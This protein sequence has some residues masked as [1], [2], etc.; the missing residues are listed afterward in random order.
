VFLITDRQ[1]V[2][3]KGLLGDVSAGRVLT[4]SHNARVL[5]VPV[6]GDATENVAVETI[7][8]PSPP[9]LQDVPVSARIT[10]RN[11]GPVPRANVN[12]VVHVGDAVLGRGSVDLPA[13]G[14]AGLVVPVRFN[15]LGPQVLSASVEE[16]AGLPD[17]NRREYAVEILRRLRVIVVTSDTASGDFSGEADLFRLSLSPFTTARRSGVDPAEVRVVSTERF[18][19]LR[20]ERPNVLVLANVNSLTPDQARDV[21]RFVLEGGGLILAPGSLSRIDQLNE[22]L[23]RNGAGVQP[24]RLLERRVVE[25]ADAARIERL[26]VNHP[27]LTFHSAVAPMPTATFSSWFGVELPAGRTSVLASLGDGAPYVISASFGRG[28]VV[29]F[30]SP[31]DA[32]WNTL[33][34][35]SFYLPLMQSITLWLSAGGMVDRN[36]A[37]GEPLVHNWAS[38]APDRVQLITPAGPVELQ[39]VVNEDGSRGVRHLQ[40]DRAGR[41]VLRASGKPGEWTFVVWGDL[42]EGDLASLSRES[43]DQLESQA[44]I[45]QVETSREA[46][47][48]ALAEFR[49]GRELWPLFLVIAML[50]AA[51]EMGL[52]QR[53]G[54]GAA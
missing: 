50:L 3:W 25:P 29:L 18:P 9:I 43:W 39:P 1:A 52:A 30:T 21:E 47:A 40:T 24:A 38:D 41:Y 20:T 5:A 31:L 34:A 23:F 19:D 44:G 2:N 13:S 32:D 27:A 14:S 16:T 7:A 17:D 22:R 11:F 10:V 48:S 54:K 35:S 42:R 8:L 46:L 53:W 49:Q 26:D 15:K 28:R 33:P 36:L 37:P 12:V 45:R 6:G 4:E 51:T